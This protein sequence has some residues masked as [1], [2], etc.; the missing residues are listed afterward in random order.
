M[1]LIALGANLPS[2]T[3]GAPRN[4]LEAALAAIS[5]SGIEVVSVSNW[6]ATTPV[7]ASD[8]PHFVN[9]VAALATDLGSGPLLDM[10]HR[11][12]ESFGRVRGERN[13]ARVLDIDLID[14]E[15]QISTDWPVLP[16][17]RMD[18]RAFVLVPLRDAA[19]D[20]RHPVTGLSVAELVAAAPDL[21]GVKQLQDGE[22]V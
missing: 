12:E 6:Y 20:W 2:P 8:Q 1:I 15:G 18:Q 21:A 19:P 7:P 16:H 22:S 11:I 10:L 5:E 17:P 4:T 14:F 13:A 9:I 3:H